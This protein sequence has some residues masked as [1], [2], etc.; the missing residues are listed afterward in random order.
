MWT[1]EMVDNRYQNHEFLCND[2][3]YILEDEHATFQTTRLH[4]DYYDATSSFDG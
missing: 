3:T 2:L 4:A 1:E